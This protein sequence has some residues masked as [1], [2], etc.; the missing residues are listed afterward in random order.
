M[1][2]DQQRELTL[3]VEN[4]MVAITQEQNQDSVSTTPAI[5]LDAA[6]SLT[7]SNKDQVLENS[8]TAANT[9]DNVDKEKENNSDDN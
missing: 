3:G 1:T 5:T 2:F 4:N 7:L 9:G 6:T 8:D